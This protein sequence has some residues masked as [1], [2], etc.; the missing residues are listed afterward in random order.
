MSNIFTHEP[1]ARVRKNWFDLGHSHK[2][3]SKFGRLAPIFVQECLPGGK[4]K[5]RSEN[6][7]RF[8]PLV[9][10]VMHKVKATVRYFFVPNRILWD[11]WDEFITGG[12]DGTSAPPLPRFGNMTPENQTFLPSDLG[13]YLGFPTN[14]D[15]DAR[16]INPLVFAAYQKI[17]YD[18][19]VDPN[20]DTTE[21]V[22][23]QSGTLNDPA[24]FTKLRNQAWRKDIYTSALPW[25]Q[26]GPTVT[27]PIGDKAEVYQAAT[28]A[29]IDS[30]PDLLW[31][32]A[33]TPNVAQATVRK[34]LEDSPEERS[35]LFADL[36]TAT[37]STITDLR[38][39]V[40]LQDFFEKLARGGHRYFEVLQRMFG[41]RNLDARLDRAEFIGGQ[42]QDIVISEVLQTSETGETPL[43]DMAGHALSASMGKN[44]TYYAPEH[45]HIIGILCVTPV[46][47][48]DQGLPRMYSRSDRFD[49]YWEQFAH[50]GEQEILNKELYY[51][52]SDNNNSL[53]FGYTPRY[54]EYRYS[55][56]RVSGA[57]RDS[58]SFWQM[59]RRFENRP[60]LNTDF[61]YMNPDAEYFTN[62][63]AVQS[64]RGVDDYLFLETYNHCKAQLPIPRYGVPRI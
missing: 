27:L 15:I 20:L 24:D 3:T 21:F 49:Y 25:A 56:N 53:P 28:Q 52:T 46:A 13:D 57:F 55:P 19:Y 35:R 12:K 50:I 18:Y 40:S 36:S 62:I 29:S 4:Y 63:F 22:P 41:V 60:Q 58:L 1:V 33:A 32:T 59:G 7:M 26:R 45:G 10:P 11:K 9:A 42:I 37:A 31:G 6:L 51:D 5:I 39:A 23:L 61:V 16:D 43:A 47:S 38:N 2:T 54:A 14:V 34:E 64:D 48:Y 44:Q 8:A 17:F 30:N